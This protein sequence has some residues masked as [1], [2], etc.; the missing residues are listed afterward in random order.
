MKKHCI[1]W[2]SLEKDPWSTNLKLGKVCVWI[3]LTIYNLNQGIKYLIQGLGLKYSSFLQT[4]FRGGGGGQSQKWYF[5]LFFILFLTLPLFKQSWFYVPEDT[6]VWLCWVLDIDVAGGYEA[7]GE[8]CETSRDLKL[9]RGE[10]LCILEDFLNSVLCLNI[11]GSY[12][13]ELSLPESSLLE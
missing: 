11:F 13:K 10:F 8:L 7:F 9:W 5:H 1:D 6:F 3:Q 2:T 4:L 12:S